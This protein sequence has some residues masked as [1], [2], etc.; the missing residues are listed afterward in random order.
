MSY[1][2]T[3]HDPVTKDVINPFVGYQYATPD[4]NRIIIFYNRLK[5]HLVRV[6]VILVFVIH[7]FYEVFIVDCSF[8]I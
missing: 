5:F 6:K 2:I 7:P 8:F 3:L 4:V 1:D